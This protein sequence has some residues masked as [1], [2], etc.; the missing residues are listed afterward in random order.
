MN[1]ERVYEGM[2]FLM[3]KFN[4]D[5]KGGLVKLFKKK[6]SKVLLKDDLIKFK[7]FSSFDSIK[8]RILDVG[9]SSVKLEAIETNPEL[10]LK[11]EDNIVLS[12]FGEKDYYVV[13]GQIGSIEKDD[14][15]TINANVYNIEKTRDLRKQNKRYVSFPGTISLAGV[16]EEN[17][18]PV[19]L[20]VV[21]LKAIRVDCSD[22]LQIGNKVNVLATLDKKNKLSFKGEIVRKNKVGNLFDYGIEVREIT[23]SNSKLMHR[24]VSDLIESES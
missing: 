4:L 20:K 3:E 21:G 8:V 24:C 11:P 7:H 17:K 13:S 15:L 18:M 12:Y 6:P 5:E 10:S 16:A 14:P 22:E 1:K 19:V 23:E 2:V 9:S